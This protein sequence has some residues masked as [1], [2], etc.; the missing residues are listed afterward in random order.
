MKTYQISVAEFIRRKRAQNASVDLKSAYR[1]SGNFAYTIAVFPSRE[2]L[3]KR[4]RK[5]NEK[6]SHWL[7]WSAVIPLTGLEGY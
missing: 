5:Q 6:P 3:A 2:S 7:N 1:A 4:V